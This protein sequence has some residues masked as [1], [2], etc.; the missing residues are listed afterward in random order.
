MRSFKRIGKRLMPNQ[1]VKGVQSNEKKYC[2][3]YQNW[4]YLG[5]WLVNYI[6]GHARG[7]TLETW[8]C[9]GESG[10]DPGG[11]VGYGP[12]MWFKSRKGGNVSHDHV[13]KTCQRI[14]CQ[15]CRQQHRYQGRGTKRTIFLLIERGGPV[16]KVLV[17]RRL[18]EVVNSR[19]RVTPDRKVHQGVYL[20]RGL[21]LLD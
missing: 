17:H 21:P 15:L 4:W 14:A 12:T 6:W 1:K 11:T 3:W 13:S 18:P 16:G 20:S 8:G 9:T 2:V 7:I 5:R 19:N 10:F